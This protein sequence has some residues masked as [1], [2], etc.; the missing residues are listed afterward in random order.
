MLL[1]I[2][3]LLAAAVMVYALMKYKKGYMWGKQV[4][5]GAAIIAIICAFSTLFTGGGP[6]T[7]KLAKKSQR[8]QQIAAQKLGSYLASEH[9]KAKTVIL[10]HMDY[11]SI[12]PNADKEKLP[13]SVEKFKRQEEALKE[14]AG[15]QLNII[16]IVHPEIPE[17][18]RSMMQPPE[19]AET[20]EGDTPYPMDFMPMEMEMMMQAEDYN[21]ALSGHLDNCD[22][23]IML[24]NL[25]YDIEKM[26]VW[27]MSSPPKVALMQPANLS[28]LKE[29]IKQGLITAVVARKPDAEYDLKGSIPND[30]EKAFNRRYLLLTPKNIEEISQKYETLFP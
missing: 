2:L 7:E 27:Q 26:Q 16:K 25:P 11:S 6:N 3:M 28:K 12:Q 24:R 8:Y 23:L 22:L 20:G 15:G 17:E 10:S 1:Y 13:T 5:V 18:A 19:G 29:P 30:V 21:N 14:G 9:P 4:A